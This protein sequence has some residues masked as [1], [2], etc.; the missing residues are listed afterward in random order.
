[1]IPQSE[2][3]QWAYA[4]DAALKGRRLTYLCDNWHCVC[5]EHNEV[6][7]ILESIELPFTSYRTTSTACILIGDGGIRFVTRSY[8]YLNPT[9]HFWDREERR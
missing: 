8:P 3:N 9:D 1:M 5:Q 4:I 7:D 2:A 6:R